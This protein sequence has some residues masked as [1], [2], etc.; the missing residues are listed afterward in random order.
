MF[1]FLQIGDRVLCWKF[2]YGTWGEY[3]EIHQ[4]HCYLMPEA[5]TF[6]EAT[7]I[8]TNYVTAYF[9]IMDFG[10]LRPGQSVFIQSAAGTL[11]EFVYIFLY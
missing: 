6:S 11:L 7:S 8:V 9:A 5:M 4:S 2:D 1:Y 10:H 3:I